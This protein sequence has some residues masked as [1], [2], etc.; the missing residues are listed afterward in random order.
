MPNFIR[1]GSLDELQIY[2]EINFGTD[3]EI[4]VGTLYLIAFLTSLTDINTAI[5]E[6]GISHREPLL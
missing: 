1:S 6:L 4:D 5:S 2:Y 3:S